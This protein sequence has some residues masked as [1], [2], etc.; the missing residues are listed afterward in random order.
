[1]KVLIVE[2]DVLSA[3]V[4]EKHIRQW[5]Y[6]VEITETGRD[7]LTRFTFTPFHVVILSLS[8]PDISGTELI[9]QLKDLRHT[10]GIL[11][12]SE[13]PARE[14]EIRTRSQGI[15]DYLMKPLDLRALHQLL[16][17]LAKKEGAKS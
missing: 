2:S 4:L 15:L 1:M 9:T 6:A 10:V 11:V 5:G 13:D 12:M 14:L 8:L 17:H 7:A 16:D 3:S